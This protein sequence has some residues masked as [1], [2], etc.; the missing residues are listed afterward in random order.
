[1]QKN[2]RY[3]LELEAAEL[4]DELDIGDDGKEGIKDDSQISDLNTIGRQNFSLLRWGK[5]N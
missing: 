4:S 3:I 1:M 5:M 2:L